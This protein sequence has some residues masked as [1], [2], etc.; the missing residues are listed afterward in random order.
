MH[1][2]LYPMN[3]M[4]TCQCILLCFGCC[5]YCP[6]SFNARTAFLS[7]LPQNS[8]PGP[9]PVLGLL[10]RKYLLVKLQSLAK[11]SHL[12]HPVTNGGPCIFLHRVSQ[13]IMWGFPALANSSKNPFPGYLLF[14]QLRMNGQEVCLL[15]CLVFYSLRSNWRKPCAHK[16]PKSFTACKFLFHFYLKTMESFSTFGKA[17]WSPFSILSHLLAGISLWTSLAQVRNLINSIWMFPI[18]I[19]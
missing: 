15:V 1:E 2:R 7:S 11:E 18:V 4:N 13:N 9:Q 16:G 17:T 6:C 19:D 10:S 8:S 12:H 5:R 14:L 3:T